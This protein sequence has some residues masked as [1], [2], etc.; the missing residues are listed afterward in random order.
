[1]RTILKKPLLVAALTLAFVLSSILPALAYHIDDITQHPFAS[2]AFKTRWERTDQPV[3][4][5][6]DRTWIWG[7]SPYTE[8]MLETYVDSPGGMRLVQYFDKSRMEINTPAA[9]TDN[10][11]YVTNGLLV[12]DM[13]EGRIQIGDGTF[14]D[15]DG[16][17]DI[18]I[19]G[20]PD[21]SPEVSYATIAELELRDEP[22]RT[23]GTL[24]NHTIDNGN[25]VQDDDFD[26]YDVTAEHRV[27][28]DH[29]DHTVASVFW[30]FMNSEGIV[31][32][33]DMTITDNLFINPFYATGYPITEAYWA[34]VNVDGFLNDVLWQCFERRCLTYTPANE[35][36]WK[37]E[38][39]NVGQH[40]FQWRYGN[41]GPV[42]ETVDIGLVAL[43]DEGVL[44]PVFG[45]DDS[46]VTVEREVQSFQDIEL[47]IRAAV[48]Q[49]LVT[50]E[51][52]LY[53]AFLGKDLMVEDVTVSG[54]I[55]SIS[56]LG[57]G[58]G[59]ACEDPRVVEQLHAT[60]TQFPGVDDIEI[61]LNGEIWEMGQM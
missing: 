30:D 61:I 45:C 43:E 41:T 10:L 55:A 58:L 37:V 40:Y 27:Q 9:V 46:L 28:I 54:G 42:M 26:D 17:A 13:I 22:A 38:A 32:E 19:A 49:L 7:P 44:G 6:Q 36:G 2:E 12:I 53:N 21:A 33:N 8:G 35:D 48:Q 11:W 31:Y 16:P 3:I 1:M 18:Q 14:V 51:G 29:I 52:D 15:A 23:S 47:L 25:I 60:A 39:G 50:E 4:D 5:G 34:Q 20:D 57:V 59:G 24:I 56:L